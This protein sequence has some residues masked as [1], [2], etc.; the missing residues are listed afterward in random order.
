MPPKKWQTEKLRNAED[1]GQQNAE[2]DEELVKCAE[3]TAVV[4]RRYLGQ[5][6]G[7]DAVTETWRQHSSTLQ[8]FNNRKY[9]FY[10]CLHHKAKGVL[11]IDFS[12][13]KWLNRLW[14]MSLLA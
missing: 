13:K 14:L 10:E 1:A 9:L 3:R 6:D 11:N 8:A 2:S 5:E 7:R 4:E 12:L